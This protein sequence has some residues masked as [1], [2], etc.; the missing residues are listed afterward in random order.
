MVKNEESKRYRITQKAKDN[1]LT[2]EQIK[3]QL[4]RTSIRQTSKS[5]LR[6]SKQLKIGEY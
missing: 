3:P 2:P 5:A 6:Q 1:T 4:K